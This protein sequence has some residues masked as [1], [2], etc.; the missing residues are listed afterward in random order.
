MTNL[1]GCTI[2]RYHILEQLGEGGMA[3]VYKA[4]DTHVEC[5]V[6]V[7]VI[8]TDQLAPSILERA[9]KRFEREAKAVA[10]LNHPNIVRVSDYGEFEGKP[11]LVMPYLKGGT[12]K[13]FLQERGHVSWQ[14]A[15]QLLVPVTEAL[16]YAH[17]NGVIHRDI[18]PSNILLTENGQPMLTDFGVAKIIGEDVTQDLTGTSATVGTPEYMAPEQVTSKTVDQR[19]DIYGLGV[20]FYEMITGRRPFEADTPLAVL[21]KHASDPLPRPTSFVR[22][23][24]DEVEHLLIKALAKDPGQRFQSMAEMKQ[25]FLKLKNLPNADIPS[26]SVILPSQ[27][28]E[29]YFA[30]KE[31]AE[32]TYSDSAENPANHPG[33]IPV[34]ENQNNQDKKNK[35]IAGICI[36]LVTVFLGLACFYLNKEVGRQHAVQTAIYRNTETQA[37]IIQNTQEA[38]SQLTQMAMVSATQKAEQEITQTAETIATQTAESM[39][40]Q[41]AVHLS[42]QYAIYYAT[43]TAQV[44]STAT[45]SSGGGAVAIPDGYYVQNSYSGDCATKPIDTVCAGFDDGYI[46]LVHES[47]LSW[48]RSGNI[49]V[50]HGNDSNFYHVL[51]T[52]YVKK[53]SK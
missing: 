44:R 12:L 26:N 37:S 22:D 18:K 13:S 28:N 10:K 30:E 46:W 15:V 38:A 52:K 11:Y 6:A 41:T 24:P 49:Q 8:R 36:A 27:L 33:S 40:T 29:N 20:V 31:T 4:F 39:I 34:R 25:A 1:I 32:E 51:G 14:E 2:E 3:V 7:K 17:E 23:L 43:Q 16:G 35:A 48:G 21:F 42:T 53:E 50:A 5:E 19:V 45:V 9:L 47:I